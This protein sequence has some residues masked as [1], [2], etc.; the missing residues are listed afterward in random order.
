MIECTENYIWYKKKGK[1]KPRKVFAFFM[2]IILIFGMC[3]YYNN[4]VCRQIFNI[5]GDY[6][7]ACS[8]EAVNSAALISLEDE[9]KYSDLINIEKNN[10]DEITL[11][12]TNS[13]KI[14]KINREVAD[15]T[16]SLIKSKLSN[17]I[18]IPA[19]AFSGI[20]FLSGYGRQINLKTVNNVSVLCDFS[21]TFT[22]VGINQTLHSI[23]INVVSTIDLEVPFNETEKVCSSKILI[24]ES[25]LVGKVPKIYLNGGLFK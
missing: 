22:S 1:N 16:C 23:Y 20:S 13:L 12:S 19:L 25:V 15:S 3:F 18:P 11:M 24:S 4:F 7:M 6:A 17:G 21:S 8:A 10:N 2:I 9:I 14:N 5:C